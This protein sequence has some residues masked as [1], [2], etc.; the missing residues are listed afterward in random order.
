M[1]FFLFLIVSFLHL[2]VAMG[3][4]DMIGP[5]RECGVKGSITLYDFKN[6]KWIYSDSADSEVQK[7]PASTFKVIHLLIA[8]ETGAVKDENTIVKW[9]GK[10]DTTLYGYR[11]EIY[12]D[13]SIKEAFEVSAGWVFMELAQK[14]GKENYLKFLKKCG[15]GNLDLSTPGIDFWNFGAFAITPKNQVE[16]MIK[17]FENKLPFSKRNIDILKKVMITEQTS[18]FTLRSKTGW[19]RW[20][21]NDIGW[22][23]GYVSTNDNHYFF[24]TRIIKRLSTINPEFG[25][26]RKKITRSVLKD[27]GAID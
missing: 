15:Y 13:M 5:F 8:L 7:L 9:P 23:V 6:K 24:A 26:C 17:V 20:E 1:K 12:H 21:G 4:V 27:Y 10:T 19:T 2:K 14:I 25:N 11:P 3:Q 16:F 18:E 22:W